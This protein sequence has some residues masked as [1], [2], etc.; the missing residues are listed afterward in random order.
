MMLRNLTLK[1]TSIVLTVILFIAGF[2]IVLYSFFMGKKLQTVKNSWSEFQIVRSEKVRLESSLRATLGYGGMIHHFKNYVLRKKN[3]DLEKTSELLG[4]AQTILNQYSSLGVS[5]AEK[6]AIEDI[7]RVV[8]QYSKVLLLTREAVNE[9]KSSD[10]IDLLAKVND[11]P[12]ILGFETLRLQMISKSDKSDVFMQ[13]K[14]LLISNLRASLGYGAMIHNFKNYVLRHDEE[15]SKKA[16]EYLKKATN[17]VN[18]YKQLGANRS[19]NVALDD[20]SKTISVYLKTLKIVH[21]SI[22]NKDS[23]EKIDKKVVIDDSLA[24]RGLITL[25]RE[26]SLRIN[27]QAVLITNLLNKISDLGKATTVGVVL[28]ILSIVILLLLL[29]QHSLIIPITGIT[30]TMNYI[31]GGHF[32]KEVPGINLKNEIGMMAR[33]V[34]IFKENSI[35]RMEAEEKIKNA[36]KKAERSAEELKKNLLVSDRLREESLKAK[37][38][39]ENANKAKSEFLAS[40]SHEIRTPMNAIIGMA[41]LLSET[42]LTQEQ[43]KYVNTYRYAGENLL[44]IINDIL[45]LSKIEAGQMEL[46]KTSFDLHELIDRTTEIMAIQAHD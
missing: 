17:I 9:K 45:D 40:M 35:K 2:L 16:E 20:I 46:E 29:I 14:G 11:T 30:E 13:N 43:E 31:A 37:E 22:K 8:N 6:K 32:D 42:T 19:E 18:I 7:E 10:E 25:D 44:N 26:V 15:Y 38:D 27:S 28:L 5:I 21:L 24:L 3:I 33:A 1:Q 41:D 39:A 23:I 34:K 36:R 4:G 12:A